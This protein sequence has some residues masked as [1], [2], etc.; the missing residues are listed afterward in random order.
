MVE[1][2]H[3]AGHL[4]A[5]PGALDAVIG[6]AREWVVTQLREEAAA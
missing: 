5:R 4:F 1:F 2:V 3:R 6:L